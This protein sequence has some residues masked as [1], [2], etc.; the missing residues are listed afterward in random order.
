MKVNDLAEMLET[1][2]V[3]I[4]EKS[5]S[6]NKLTMVMA[7]LL[8]SMPKDMVEQFV[9]SALTK[10]AENEEKINARKKASLERLKDLKT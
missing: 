4:T 3:K 1:T 5:R 2:A 9:P 8:L 6:T 7:N 10:Y